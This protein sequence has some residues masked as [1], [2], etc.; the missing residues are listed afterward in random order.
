MATRVDIE[1]QAYE[2]PPDD[3]VAAEA[4]AAE[5]AEGAEAEAKPEDGSPA[6]EA[7]PA[8][9]DT[10]P[11]VP[12]DVKWACEPVSE[13]MVDALSELAND[14]RLS[15]QRYQNEHRDEFNSKVVLS[16]GSASMRGL[17][18]FM[19]AEIGMGIPTEVSNPWF[20]IEVDADEISE[21]YLA[22]IGPTVSVAVGLALRDMLD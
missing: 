21:D 8:V 12:E 20:G 10:A 19:E 18:Q 6:D 17:A 3:T 9:E 14:I 22:Q 16:G 15:V 2:L 13:A 1:A 4:D 5:G 11:D 7:T